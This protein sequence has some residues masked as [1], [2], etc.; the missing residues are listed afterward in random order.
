MGTERKSVF[1]ELLTI[2]DEFRLLDSLISTGMYA[3]IT[4]TQFPLIY[5]T[6]PDLL[7]IKRLDAISARISL[8]E[9]QSKYFP[10]PDSNLSKSV[11]LL[12][13]EAAETMRL[14]DVDGIESTIPNR[15]VVL[16]HDAKGIST[17]ID[18]GMWAI[19]NPTNFLSLQ[20]LPPQEIAILQAQAVDTRISQLRALHTNG[21]GLGN[22][23][24][25]LVQ[26]IA[27]ELS[28]LNKKKEELVLASLYSDNKQ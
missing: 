11:G 17:A 10:D 5:E 23:H 19:I 27:R 25:E 9:R 24:D 6:D 12:L 14:L 13:D 16:E 15:V 3:V 18:M 8:V 20:G 28:S 4:Q 7:L 22:S 26:N 1:P 21:F 2:A